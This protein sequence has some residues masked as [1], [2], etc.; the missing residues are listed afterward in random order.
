VE[1]IVT[2]KERSIWIMFPEYWRAIREDFDAEE[3]ELAER[4]S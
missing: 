2:S 4:S 3:L 1:S